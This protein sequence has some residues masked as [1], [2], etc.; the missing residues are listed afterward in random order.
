[1][2]ETENSA[3]VVLVTDIVSAYVANNSVNAT[4]LPE[5]ISSVHASAWKTESDIKASSAIFQVAA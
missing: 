2:T 4:A 5:L 1:M 3:A